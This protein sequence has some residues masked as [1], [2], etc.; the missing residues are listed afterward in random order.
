MKSKH[1]EA[2]TSL[3]AG[4][5]RCEFPSAVRAVGGGQ[6]AGDGKASAGGEQRDS[7]SKGRGMASAP[8]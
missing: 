4:S 5:P 6:L 3:A 8:A 2:N 7:V 1:T